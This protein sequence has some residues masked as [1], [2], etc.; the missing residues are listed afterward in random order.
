MN[1]V[2]IYFITLS[3]DRKVSF[4]DMNAG[5][6]KDEPYT[7]EKTATVFF[8]VLSSFP[9]TSPFP[10]DQSKKNV[11]IKK[12]KSSKLDFLQSLRFVLIALGRLPEQE[13]A[14]RLLL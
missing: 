5:F 4:R 13:P 7:R 1:T 3:E 2:K 12:K 14:R 8:R 11:G 9:K 6:S 10:Q